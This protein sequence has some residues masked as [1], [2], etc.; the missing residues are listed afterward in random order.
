MTGWHAAHLFL[1]GAWLGLVLAEGVLEFLG[2][3]G[4]REAAMTAR[5]HVWI[6]R[7]FELP[8]LLGVLATGAVLTART[9]MTAALALKIV[10]G[11]AAIGVNLWC[12]LVVIRR[13]RLSSASPEALAASRRVELAFK[14]GTPPALA[15]LYMGLR[16]TGRF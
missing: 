14:L 1:L 4:D 6:D 2:R 12:A 13:E 5:A 15:A 11:L 7:L 10:L 3:A 8:I 16:L 9:P